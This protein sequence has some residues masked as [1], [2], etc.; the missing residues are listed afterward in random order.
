MGIKTKQTVLDQLYKSKTE[1]SKKRKLGILQDID[2]ELD[3]MLQDFAD[4]ESIVESRLSVAIEL[5]ALLGQEYIKAQD[6]L[7]ARMEINIQLEEYKKKA[8]DLG[9]DS[10][11]S[12]YDNALDNL[13]TGI[14]FASSDEVL[15]DLR[16]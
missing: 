8:N 4:Y 12:Y 1:L 10:D 15:K 2:S 14:Q 16:F 3:G 13:K 6:L 11:T 7:D 9:V 5:E